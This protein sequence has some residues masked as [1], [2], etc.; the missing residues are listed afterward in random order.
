VQDLFMSEAPPL[1]RI[2]LKL[3]RGRA[4]SNRSAKHSGCARGF[5]CKLGGAGVQLPRWTPDGTVRA[6]HAAVSGARPQ[7]LVTVGAF[8]EVYTRVLGHLFLRLDT[9]ERA[10][11]RASQN[12]RRHCLTHRG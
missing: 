6:K 2:A 5:K 4:A 1:Q 8:K 12:E 9:A 7:H 10:R 3:L 11:D